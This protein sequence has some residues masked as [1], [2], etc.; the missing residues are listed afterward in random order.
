METRLRMLIVLA[1]LP[2]PQVQVSIHD[3]DGRFLGRPD[4]LYGSHRL[5]I[6]YDGGNHRERMVDDNRRQNRLVGAG[7]RLLRFT[8]A[9]VYDK[10][11]SV[12][13][14]VRHGLSQKAA[15]RG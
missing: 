8:A 11:D 10:P 14:Q 12:A 2:R 13:I 6:E 9:D 1:K 4:L 3:D 15:L 5:A 7:Y